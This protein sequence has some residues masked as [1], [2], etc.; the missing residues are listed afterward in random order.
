MLSEV[1]NAVDNL[2]LFSMGPYSNSLIQVERTSMW[3]CEYFQSLRVLN[4]TKLF[5]HS[6]HILILKIG[7]Y[8]D[9]IRD[10]GT[11]VMSF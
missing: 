1:R 2:P 11:S 7:V 9:R 3:K 10:Q 8:H 6:A 5:N 4:G